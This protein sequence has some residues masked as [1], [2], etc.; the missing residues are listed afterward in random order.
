[1]GIQFDYARIKGIDAGWEHLYSCN[2]SIR[3][4]LLEKI[5]GFDEQRFPF[6]Y[7]DLDLGLR[8]ARHGFR[9]LFNR[10]AEGQHLKT[11][12]L[13]SW[14]R[15]LPRIAASERQFVATYPDR[16]PYFHDLF[17]TAAAAPAA[18]GRAAR[19]A[20]FI[21]PNVPGLGR[22]VWESYHMVCMQALAPDFLAAWE[23]D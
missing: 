23:R 19:L 10:A 14:R 6:G 16:R 3:R 11:E 13:E 18:R 22:R 5:G 20:R 1:M 21:P 9:L 2:V 8:L 7:E 15:K 4:A 12:T 17:R